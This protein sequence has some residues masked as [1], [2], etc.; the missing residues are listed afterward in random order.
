VKKHVLF[1]VAFI[2][3][4]QRH[5]QRGPEAGHDSR[6]FDAEPDPITAPAHPTHR[7][8]PRCRGL[9]E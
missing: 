8:S 7:A 3:A 4:I 1:S 9:V 2:S 6:P 5:M